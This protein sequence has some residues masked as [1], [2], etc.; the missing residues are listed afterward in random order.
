MCTNVLPVCMHTMYMP[1]AFGDQ[2][3]ALDTLALGLHMVMSHHVG[4]EN[5]TWVLSKSSQCLS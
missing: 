2:K 3:K 5:E 1:G 4:A